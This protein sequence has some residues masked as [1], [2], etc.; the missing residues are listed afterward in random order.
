MYI[1]YRRNPG[2]SIPFPAPLPF[3]TEILLTFQVGS[4]QHPSNPLAKN[5]LPADIYPGC[6]DFLAEKQYSSS[7]QSCTSTTTISTICLS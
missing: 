6:N 3:K 4:P 1:Q 5:A 7:S 2:T